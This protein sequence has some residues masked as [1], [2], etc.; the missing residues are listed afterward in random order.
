L[1]A[2]KLKLDLDEPRE[3][4]MIAFGYAAGRLARPN[5]KVAQ[6]VDLPA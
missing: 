5:A 1:E 3:A 4:N 2:G 6:L